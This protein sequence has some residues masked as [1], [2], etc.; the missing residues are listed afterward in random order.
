MQEEIEEMKKR[1]AEEVLEELRNLRI[2][3]EDGKITAEEKKRFHRE[4]EVFVE[5]ISDIL[6]NYVDFRKILRFQITMPSGLK[7]YLYITPDWTLELGE[8]LTENT[9]LQDYTGVI[10]VIFGNADYDD[11]SWMIGLISDEKV[12][13][14]GGILYFNDNEKEWITRDEAFERYLDNASEEEFTEEKER[15]LEEMKKDLG[16]IMGDYI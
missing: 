3:E 7:K 9:R 8:T 2:K 16:I 15:I 1:D 12:D 13:E 6:D 5:A 10:G 11:D 14:D 4:R